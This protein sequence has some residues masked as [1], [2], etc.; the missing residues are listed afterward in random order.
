M[1]FFIKVELIDGLRLI[2]GCTT[3]R[4][5]A[6]TQWGLGKYSAVYAD[7]VHD[8]KAE[9]I[10]AGLTDPLTQER[11]VR[12]PEVMQLTGISKTTVYDYIRRGAFPKQY[13][14]TARISAWKLSE[15]TAWLQT[16]TNGGA[17]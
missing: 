9:S 17:V 5:Y 1:K 15:I 6:A 14:L 4:E 7:S 13:H 10:R 16:R 8:L 12:L 2:T 3:D 11:F